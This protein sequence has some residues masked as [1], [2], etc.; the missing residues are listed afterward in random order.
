MTLLFYLLTYHSKIIEYIDYKLY[1]LTSF[2]LKSKSVPKYSSNCVIVDIDE[3]SIQELGQWPWSRIIMAY[4][5][6]KID[7]MYPTVIGINIL[8][9]DRDRTSPFAIEKFYHD[10][11]NLDIK[12]EP[13]PE[14]LKDNDKIFAEAI[15]NTHAVLS[16]YMYSQHVFLKNHQKTEYTKQDFSPLQTAF[17]AKSILSNYPVLQKATE[18]FGFINASMDEDGIFR[19]IPLFIKYKYNLI[20]SFSL[21][22]LLSLDKAKPKNHSS[23]SILGHTV[24]MDKNSN[25][26]LNYNSPSIPKISAI[27]ILTNRAD[28]QKIKGKIVLIGSSVSGLKHTFLTANHDAISAVNIHAKVIDNI[29]NNS[30]LVQPQLYKNINTF[31]SLVLSFLMLLLLFKQWYI[32]LLM[33]FFTA[34][35]A[36]TIWLVSLYLKGIYPSIGYLWTPFTVYFFTL[37]LFFA[38][39]NHKEKRRFYREL[40]QAHS[41]ALESITFVAAMRDDE[42]GTHLI[43]TKNYVRLLAEY[44]YEQKL[45]H[46][47]L[48]PKHIHLLYEAAPLHDIGKV[49][50]PDNILKKKGKFTPQEYEIMKEHTILGKEMIEKA[51]TSYNKNEFLQIACSIAYHHH[52]RWDGKGYPQGLKGDEIPIEGQLMALADVYD[53]LISKRV[54]KE[55]FSYEEAEKIIMQERGKIFNPLIVD[56]FVALKYEFRRISYQYRQEEKTR[57][58]ET[59]ISLS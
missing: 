45:Y 56:A 1:D 26:L 20:P 17:R 47:Y 40:D 23:F 27:D 7:R 52:E 54:Y 28:P 19:R 15:K 53:A 46:H 5:I 38:L 25:V 37:T 13:V 8:F 12:I 41:A 31:I 6:E 2:I 24:T 22:I 51:M 30:L 58:R 55:A 48:T 42:T 11:F 33:L 18:D 29:L 57:K 4:L 49:G 3:K 10:F 34:V 35:I 21:A 9:P 36:S 39:I 32:R 14:D 59:E 50:I 44:L 43:R 16:V